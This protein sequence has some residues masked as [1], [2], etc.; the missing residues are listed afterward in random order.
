[1][2]AGHDPALIFN[3]RFCAAPTA[4]FNWHQLRQICDEWKKKH[5]DPE[6]DDWIHKIVED[7]QKVWQVSGTR[8]V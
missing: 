3:P 2:T 7:L 6:E 4:S 8:R 1:M 5:V